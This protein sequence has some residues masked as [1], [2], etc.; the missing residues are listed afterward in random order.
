MT[1]LPPP[2]DPYLRAGSSSSSP[3]I[4][5]SSSLL[6]VFERRSHAIWPDFPLAKTPSAVRSSYGIRPQANRKMHTPSEYQSLLYPLAGSPL[7]TSGAM[8]AGDPANPFAK[9]RL[10]SMRGAAQSSFARSTY[11]SDDSAS[12]PHLAG[13]SNVNAEAELAPALGISE[14]SPG[15]ERRLVRLCSPPKAVSPYYV[16]EPGGATLEL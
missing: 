14:S 3:T 13:R 10:S 15:S 9:S 16:A 7:I 8:K 5:S 11:A 12:T 4:K 2:I 6:I 1:R